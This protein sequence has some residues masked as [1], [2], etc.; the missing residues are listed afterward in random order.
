MKR[1]T[2]TIAGIRTLRAGTAGKPT[3]VLFHGYGASADDLYSL[4]QLAPDDFTWLFPEGILKIFP[5][6]RAWFPIDLNRI[7]AAHHDFETFEHTFPS[8]WSTTHQQ[9]KA[10]LDALNIPPSQLILGGF[11]QGAIVA[12]ELSFSFQENIA[13]LLILSGT[14]IHA[15]SWNTQAAKHPGMRFFQ[16]HGTEDAIL[17]LCYAKTLHTLLLS[18]G[19]KGTLHLFEDG[20]QIPDE[21]LEQLE[22]FLHALSFK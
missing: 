12:T 13:A 22:Q 1:H 8:E 11:S 18:A 15:A 10:F 2:E 5:F 21:T 6:G 17:P 20:H 7:C 4:H 3:I 16:S 19:W 14:L 9:L